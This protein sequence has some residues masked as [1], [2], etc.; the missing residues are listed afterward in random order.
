MSVVKTSAWLI[1]AAA[2]SPAAIVIALGYR[3]AARRAAAGRHRHRARSP[4]R[5]SAAVADALRRCRTCGEEQRQVV[6]VALGLREHRRRRRA[7]VDPRRPA[8]RL[9]DARRHRRLDADPPLLDRLHGRRPRLRALLRVPEL[10]RLL[11]AAAGPGGQLPPAHRRLGVRRRGVVPADLVLVPARRRR[12]AAGIKAFVINVVGDV[13]LV[14]GTFFI[15]KHTGTLDFLGT[16]ERRRASFARATATSPPGCI[17]LLVGAFAKSA[18]IPLHTWLPDAMEGPT[19]VSAL[20]HAATMVTAGVYLIARMHPLFEQSRRRPPTSARSSAAL[21][22]LVAGHD[23][24][25]SSPTSSASSP[26]RR[27]RRSAT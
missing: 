20:I 18:Q 2:R 13:G 17:L 10:L 25:S 7:A 16:F 19:P 24:R 3:R 11:D 26:T 23:R 1:L 15:F 22:L 8:E 21:T 6:S 9:H 14:L 5:S 27:C 4:P 12:R